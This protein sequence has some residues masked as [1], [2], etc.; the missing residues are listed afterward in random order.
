LKLQLNLNKSNEY[1]FKNLTRILLCSTIAIVAVAR[2]ISPR[3]PI[4]LI[5]QVKFT[6]ENSS[7]AKLNTS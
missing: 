3:N 1:H 5:G 4:A 7:G 6:L 2:V